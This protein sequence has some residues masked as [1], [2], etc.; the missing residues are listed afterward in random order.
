M[1]ILKE[2][3]I[4]KLKG[5]QKD[6]VFQKEKPKTVVPIKPVISEDKQTQALNRIAVEIA[7]LLQAND[8]NAIVLMKAIKE[9]Q[10]LDYSKPVTNWDFTVSR[11]QTGFIKSISAKAI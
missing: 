4:R 10:T 11:D 5:K 8:K 7:L 9:A 3:D 6:Q 1:K 2:K